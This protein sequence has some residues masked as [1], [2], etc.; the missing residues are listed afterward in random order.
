MEVVWMGPC[1][2]ATAKLHKWEV[3]QHTSF[4][5]SKISNTI[6][7]NRH[8]GHAPGIQL[9]NKSNMF[10]NRLEERWC[11]TLPIF[12]LHTL[13]SDCTFGCTNVGT[14][15]SSSRNPAKHKTFE[16]T[17]GCFWKLKNF[18]TFQILY[19][20]MEKKRSKEKLL[21]KILVRQWKRFSWE[22]VGCVS[23]CY[24][25]AGQDSDEPVLSSCGQEVSAD[26]ICRSIIIFCI[27]LL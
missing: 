16:E 25:F 15:K 5:E 21:T 7:S 2:P 23:S 18:L 9:V 6:F 3:N 22:V 14:R 19:W 26:D 11:Q 24:S 8:I 1:L 10:C 17:W 20:Y 4:Q 27:I 13:V 12:K